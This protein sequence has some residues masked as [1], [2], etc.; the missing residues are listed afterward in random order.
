VSV[1][2]VSPE[3]VDLPFHNDVE[4]GVV[5]HLFADDVARS[6]EEFTQQLY[7]AEFDARRLL[8]D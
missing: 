2:L 3:H 5:E 4:I 7:S 8:L 6:L 1:N